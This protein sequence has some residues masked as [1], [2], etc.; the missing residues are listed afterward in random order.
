MDNGERQWTDGAL[1]RKVTMNYRRLLATR[2]GLNKISAQ[3]KERKKLTQLKQFHHWGWKSCQN[4]KHWF[5]LQYIT[6]GAGE[7]VCVFLCVLVCVSV[8][9]LALTKLKR[10]LWACFWKGRHN[11]TSDACTRPWVQGNMWG[12]PHRCLLCSGHTLTGPSGL[13][14][15]D[16]GWRGEEWMWKEDKV[17]GK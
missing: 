12:G 7:L 5:I 17:G 4:N 15:G 11:V 2:R 10:R 13:C 3:I 6:E 9:D 14:L 1:S 8:C 16:A